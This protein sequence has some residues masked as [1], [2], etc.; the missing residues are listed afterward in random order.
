[1]EDEETIENMFSMFQTLVAGLEVL[2]KGYST[3]DHVNK[4]IRSLPKR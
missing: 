2:N 1:M 4:I 3:S